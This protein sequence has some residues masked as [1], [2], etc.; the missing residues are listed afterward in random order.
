M[1]KQNET[2]LESVSL[3]TAVVNLPVTVTV[4]VG[5]HHRTLNL[6]AIPDSERTRLVGHLIAR[7]LKL[8]LDNPYSTTK[9]TVQERDQAA[10]KRFNEIQ[11]G[12]FQ[13]GG[14]GGG[15]RLTP[16]ADGWIEWLKASGEKTANG[17]TLRGIQLSKCAAT[18][19]NKGK[20]T[21]ENAK[22][23]AEAELDKWIAWQQEHNP[24]L[25]AII[26][27]KRALATGVV[28]DDYPG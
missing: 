13:P 4:T 17:K 15:P 16:E 1:A 26:G 27:A 9:G 2:D 5:G 22:V 6:V 14:G 12:T 25:K 11:D 7:G 18:L 28:Q 8:S 21:K 24:S 10:L 3:A 19:V 20:A 23:M